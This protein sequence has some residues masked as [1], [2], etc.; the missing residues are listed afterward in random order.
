MEMAVEKTMADM[1]QGC[2]RHNKNRQSVSYDDY[3]RVDRGVRSKLKVEELIS[4]ARRESPLDSTLQ[5]GHYI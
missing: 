3:T 5:R 1:K 2:L 4:E